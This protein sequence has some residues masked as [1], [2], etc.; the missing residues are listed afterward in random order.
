[1]KLKLDSNENLHKV[2]NWLGSLLAVYGESESLI[3]VL[4]AVRCLNWN[5]E[6]WFQSTGSLFH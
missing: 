6:H 1:M 3:R 5:L 4:R 2:V